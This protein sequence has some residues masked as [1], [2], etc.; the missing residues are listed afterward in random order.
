MNEWF[1]VEHKSGKLSTPDGSRRINRLAIEGRVG[2]GK[3]VYEALDGN[4][5]PA[6]R[7]QMQEFLESKLNSLRMYPLDK[8]GMCH[9]IEIYPLETPRGE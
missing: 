9:D 3:Y 1:Y 7:M 4:I 6:T 5:A 2:V 8:V